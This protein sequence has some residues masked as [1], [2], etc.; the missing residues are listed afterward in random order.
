MM[1]KIIIE[2]NSDLDIDDVL[3]YVGHVIRKGKISSTSKG[4]QYCFITTFE[5][6]IYVSSSKNKK[7]DR[8]IVG[9]Y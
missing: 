3:Q 9:N 5:N 7:S 4:D 6:G 8:F 2:N 1:E